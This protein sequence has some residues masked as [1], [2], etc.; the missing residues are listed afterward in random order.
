MAKEA[1]AK[2]K[3]VRMLKKKG[4]KDMKAL[5]ENRKN[6]KDYIDVIRE[7]TR[8]FGIVHCEGCS[9]KKHI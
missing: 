7:F 2:V 5:S 3:E 1:K 4:M 8:C 6:S 9:Y